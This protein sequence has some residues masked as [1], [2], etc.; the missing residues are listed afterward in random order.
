MEARRTT[1]LDRLT[2][3]RDDIRTTRTTNQLDGGGPSHGRYSKG[4]APPS[5]T[6]PVVD[7]RRIRLI[8][9]QLTGGRPGFDYV[10]GRA[11]S[12]A[13]DLR[14]SPLLESVAQKALKVSCQASPNV[15]V[16]S[17]SAF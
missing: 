14:G 1:R 2:A 12:S 13:F 7:V 3:D 4:V 8:T 17:T 6:D 15:I 10:S 16:E 9:S 11:A 5:L